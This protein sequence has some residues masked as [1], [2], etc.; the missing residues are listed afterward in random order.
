MTSSRFPETSSDMSD[1]SALEDLIQPFQ[2]EDL[3]LRGRFVRLG[4]AA[5]AV[6][7]PHGYPA[8]V[9]ELMGE[10]LALTAVLGGAL[11]FDGV[12]KLQTQGDGPVSFMVTDMTDDGDLR[13]YARYDAEAVAAVGDPGAAPVPRLLGAGRM[14]VTVDHGPN[15]QQHQGITELSGA[16]LADCA[17]TYFRQSEPVETVIAL[18]AAGPEGEEPR[19]AALMIQRLPPVEGSQATPPERDLDDEW[20]RAVALTSSVTPAEMLDPA[21]PPPQLLYRLYHEDGVRLFRSRPV[22]HAC[23]CSRERVATTLKSFAPA[24]ID[25]MVEDEAI[26][27]TCEFCKSEYAFS[28]SDLD[29]LRSS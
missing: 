22:R 29:D 10:M 18:T 3:G 15:A 11:R 16:R 7:G 21:I 25:S 14:A 9:A 6:L 24:D 28:G 20:R 5:Q 19:A 13:G 17:H 26:T 2:I 27:V 8:P 1:A 23:R 4:P 12:F